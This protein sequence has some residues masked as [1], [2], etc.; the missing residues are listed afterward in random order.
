MRQS[1]TMIPRR[2]RRPA[3][4]CKG[5]RAITLIEVLTTVALLLI[6][7]V[8][9][10]GILSAVTE[11]GQRHGKARQA[12]TSVDRLAKIFRSDV[13]EAEDVVIPEAEW[14]L[15]L[16]SPRAVVR[17][18]WDAVR[19]TFRRS[20][21]SNADERNQVDRFTLPEDCEP[22]VTASGGRV[23]LDLRSPQLHADWAIEATLG[24]GEDSAR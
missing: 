3:S 19:Q 12:R 4:H 16:R 2:A 14:P 1:K 11:I 10:A 22:T 9:S 7:A 18:E 20:R 17:Y 23:R 24:N 15:E 5:R 13:R 8:A 6:L 21:E